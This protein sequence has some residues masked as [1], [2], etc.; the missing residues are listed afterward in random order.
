MFLIPMLL[1]CTADD[2]APVDTDTP[3]DET[4]AELAYSWSFAV[5]ADPHIT[6]LVEREERLAAAVEWINTNETD[7]SIDFVVVVGDIGWGGGLEI[8]KALLDDLTVPYVPVIGDNE[9]HFGD[10]ENFATV[11]AGVYDNLAD[12]LTHFVQET[13]QIDNPEHGRVS[14]FHN[15]SFDHQ[16]V[17]V[18]AMDWNSRSDGLAGEGADLHDFEGG[19]YRWFDE[20]L[21]AYEPGD[22]ADLLFFSHEPMH[23]SPGA[24]TTEEM[25]VVAALTTP[26]SGR[27]GGAWSGHYHLNFDLYNEVGGYD[28]MIT[29]ATWDDE[30]AIRMV[31]VWTNGQRQEYVNEIIPIEGW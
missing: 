25:D 15:L 24:F 26:L 4:P 20:Q 6:N 11:F 7:R 22:Q 3:V 21:A 29:D 16:G 28:V 5:I 31:D 23:A 13:V 17:H 18:M 9:I 14:W 8:A 2:P 12:E 27:I 19:T 30:D 1:S 10:E